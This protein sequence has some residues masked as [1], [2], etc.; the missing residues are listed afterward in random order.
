MIKSKCLRLLL[1]AASLCLALPGSG[2]AQ[3]KKP[4]VVFSA[5]NLAFPWTAFTA[6]VG[7]DEGSKLGVDVLVQDG[8]GSSSK[9]SSDLRN[10]VNQGVGGIVL[11]PND[12]KALVPAV[13]EVL[14]ANIPIVTVDRYIEG[15]SKAVPHYGVDNVAGGRKMADYAMSKF[16]NGFRA[17][18]LTG[19]PGSSPA[20]DRA[21]GIREAIKQ[22]GD[23]FKLVGDQT[24]NWSR[25]EGL[26]VTQNILTALG[27]PPDVIFA[28]NDDM[29]LGALQALQQSGV[30]KGKVLVLGYDAIPEGL[31]KVRDGEMA[32][33][34]EQLP[35]QQVKNAMD[36]VA[37]YLKD[38]K[39][40][41]SLRLDPILITKDNLQQAERFG[42]LK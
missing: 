5:P 4:K 33:T 6:K 14:A 36:A 8:Q 39:P 32:A 24:A 25:A 34:V 22:A 41:E 28:S 15:A 37:M 20:I 21:K 10:A 12:V 38:K 27:N 16:P 40:L 7:K 29:G 17:I 30:P 35:G 1:S 31:A 11:T 18:L 42:E 3:S 9:Q 2:H 23:K 26:T 19:Q 13:N